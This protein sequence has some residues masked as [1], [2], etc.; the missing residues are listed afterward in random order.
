MYISFLVKGRGSIA[1]LK[2]IENMES[3]NQYC[4]LAEFLSSNIS[5]VLKYVIPTLVKQ[6]I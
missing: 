6:F 4:L 3:N 2:Y 1:S 5:S